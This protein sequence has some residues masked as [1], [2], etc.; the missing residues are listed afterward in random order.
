[1]ITII[2]VS[3]IILLTGAAFLAYYTGIIG[4]RK[5]ASTG[6]EQVSQAKIAEDSG[7]AE[8]GFASFETEEKE[9]EPERASNNLNLLLSSVDHD[10]KMLVLNDEGSLVT[11][12]AFTTAVEG[13][14]E[15]FECEDYDRDG[16]IYA[17]DLVSGEY[18]VS[19]YNEN[20]VQ[21]GDP[22]RVRV[23]EEISY[24]PLV[25]I[26]AEVYTEDEI[27]AEEEDTEV[28]ERAK[29]ETE[30]FVEN[31][32]NLGNGSVGVDVSK[33]NKEI[34]WNDVRASGIEFAIIRIGYR[35]SSSGVLV[36]D[37]YFVKNLAG[38]KAAGMKIGVYFFTQAVNVTEAVEEASAI[39]TLVGA[40]ELQLPVFM[41]VES[42]GGRADGL[43]P[44]TRTEIINAF[45]RTL[46][47]AGYSAGVYLNKRWY[48][49]KIDRE[50][51][52]DWKLWLA[53]Y[54]ANE[55]GFPCDCWQYTSRGSVDG[56]VG[57]VDLDVNYAL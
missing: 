45:C 49:S 52:G 29:E 22:V 35:G 53:R 41:D 5:S 43:D 42:S 26:E 18:A 33:Y 56:I 34:N 24:T 17:S 20:G 30:P 1:M 55:P 51:L 36:V 23:R 54:K 16:V 11:G 40:D 38:A 31:S 57:N 19:L 13:P 4:N 2:T 14:E 48:E 21:V 50:A 32:V 39:T 47:S 37:P 46:E 10:I 12:K 27:D 25:N 44:G 8:P 9:A 6:E 15:S 28:Y 7:N 3:L